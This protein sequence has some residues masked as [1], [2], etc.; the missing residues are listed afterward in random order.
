M[1]GS[2]LPV[3][4]ACRGAYDKY[5]ADLDS[6]A[7]TVGTRA[8]RAR[9]VRRFLRWLAADGGDAATVLARQ[10]AWDDAVARFITGLAASAG[11]SATHGYRRALADCARRLGLAEPPTTPRFGWLRDNYAAALAS[12]PRTEATIRANLTTVGSF[13][14]W[15]SDTGYT[16]DLRRDWGTTVERYL[17]DLAAKGNATSSVW[18]RRW[19]LNDCAG[20]LGLPSAQADHG[21]TAYVPLRRGFRSGPQPPGARMARFARTHDY[22][23]GGKDNTAIDQ[24]VGEQM[25]RLLPSIR[26]QARASRLFLAGAVRYLAAEHHIRQFLDIGLAFPFGDST[27]EVAQRVAPGCKIVYAD[28]DPV[29]LAYARALLTSHS[30]GACDYVDADL[31][32][33]GKILAGAAQT[34]DLTEPVALLL[35]GALRHLADDNEAAWA[36]GE[37]TGALA[38]GS[39]VAISHPANVVHGAASDKAWQYWNEH[40]TPKVAVRSRE[41][42]AR[43]LQGLEL[44]EPG[45]VSC[46]R[47]RPD[48]WGL[49][50]EVDEFCGLAHKP[51]SSR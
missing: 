49:P 44:L 42:I 43:F 33:P 5:L 12:S 17:Q 48:P 3:P 46:F 51:G 4:E 15:L 18:V 8:L 9:Y 41:Q 10:D 30:E 19:A 47:W 34:L 14:R 6:S 23:L 21:G 11:R 36:V 32:E 45:L 28:H 2:Q 26:A 50:A 35:L 27:H 20:R 37:L 1:S 16:G 24:A 31:H 40:G 7:F 22:W 25:A 39:Y 29:L 38:P 13:L